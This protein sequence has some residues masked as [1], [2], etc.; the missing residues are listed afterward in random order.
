MMPLFRAESGGGFHHANRTE[1]RFSAKALRGGFAPLH[2]Y[3]HGYC[4]AAGQHLPRASPDRPPI[5]P[6]HRLELLTERIALIGT[7]A[8]NC[9]PLA[10]GPDQSR[11]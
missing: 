11:R 4:S 7:T 5:D 8:E 1:W 6:S 3:Y 10:L 9:G 2:S